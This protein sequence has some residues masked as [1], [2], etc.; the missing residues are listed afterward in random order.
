[1]PRWVKTGTPPMPSSPR[2][3]HYDAAV[4]Q[5]WPPARDDQSWSAP[6]KPAQNPVCTLTPAARDYLASQYGAHGRAPSVRLRRA[7]SP[8]S[9]TSPGRCMTH[10]DHRLPCRHPPS[11]RRGQ[12]RRH[13]FPPAVQPGRGPLDVPDRRRGA[14]VRSPR[15]VRPVSQATPRPVPGRARPAKPASRS[16]LAATCWDT[17]AH[18]RTAPS[19]RHLPGHPPA[20]YPRIASSPDG[21][22]L[23]PWPSPSASTAPAFATRR[24]I[25]APV[26]PHRHRVRLVHAA[27]S[28]ILTEHPRHRNTA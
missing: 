27:I 12:C 26:Q 16:L 3:R 10:A 11:R 20:V 8:R 15:L 7:A 17:A 14:G 6:G 18:Q 1:M 5:P 22:L 4:P 2:T 9:G 25:A 24:A 28:R 21:A 23:S 13:L 19:R